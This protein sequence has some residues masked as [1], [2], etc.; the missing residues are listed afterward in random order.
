MILGLIG[1]VGSGKSTVTR[2]LQDEYGFELLL[3][4]DIAKQLELPGGSCYEAIVK[5]FGEEILEDG[6]GS[7]IANPKLAAKIY[8]DPKSLE[9][10]NNIV[11]PAVWRYVSDYID[12][13]LSNN[14]DKNAAAEK[15]HETL[16]KGQEAADKLRKAEQGEAACNE[17]GSQED[18]RIAIE[19]ALPNDYFRQLCDE[20]WFIYTDREIRTKRLMSDRGYT[21]AKSESIIAGQLSD[22]GFKA[23]ADIV[24]DNSGERGLAEAAVRKRLSQILSR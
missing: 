7:R 18:V 3:T 19:T 16:S 2:V 14:Q 21:R 15:Q 4:D 22:A 24:I 23:A 10:I 17:Y 1:G 12:N 9:T 8:A 5:A 6:V 20:V 13:A 11:H